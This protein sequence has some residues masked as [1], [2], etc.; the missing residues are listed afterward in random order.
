MKNKYFVFTIC[1]FGGIF[2]AQSA[3]ATT[4]A[5]V[6][7]VSKYARK[8]L[9]YP[10]DDAALFYN[11][12]VG[13][14]GAGVKPE[15]STFLINEKATAA[16]ILEAMKT[17][18]AKAQKDDT[19]IFF[20]SGHGDKGIFLSYGADTSGAYLQHAEVK[21]AFK[22]CMAKT[23]LC[24]AD[25]CFSGTLTPNLDKNI[26]V[27]FAE[28]VLKDFD[29]NIVVMMSSRSN[30]LSQ[31]N[32]A[33]KQGA[34]AYYLVKGLKGDAD[35]DKNKAIIISELFAYVSK[36]VVAFTNGAQHP[37]LTG[38]FDRKMLLVKF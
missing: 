29:S 31:E 25:A 12:L 30:E 8:P 2:F 1:L 15:N 13:K 37:I 3:A 4:Y 34:F 22:A 11:W 16:A 5:V 10:D 28:S 33:L 7:G 20:F 35:V 27:K 9:R 19:V 23:K 14:G 26:S 36:N 24:F 6:S 32:A 21:A 38:K 17:Q 18:F